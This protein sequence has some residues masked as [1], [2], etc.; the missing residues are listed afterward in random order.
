MFTAQEI[1]MRKFLLF[2][3]GMGSIGYVR[4]N[5]ADVTGS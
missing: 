2:L 5:G 3:S 4:G 1:F